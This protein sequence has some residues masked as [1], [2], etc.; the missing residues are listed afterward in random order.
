MKLNQ[1]RDRVRGCSVRI[2]K[3]RDSNS[4]W[5]RPWEGTSIPDSQILR[6]EVEQIEVYG[7]VGNAET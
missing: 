7:F 5:E 6:N 3:P 1:E 4:C 2:L